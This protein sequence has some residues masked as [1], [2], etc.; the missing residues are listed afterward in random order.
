[1][2]CYIRQVVKQF[3]KNSQTFSFQIQTATFKLYRI[4]YKV[5]LL[6]KNVSQVQVSNHLPDSFTCIIFSQANLQMFIRFDV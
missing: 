6:I 4:T 3:P 2:C 1:M 5:N